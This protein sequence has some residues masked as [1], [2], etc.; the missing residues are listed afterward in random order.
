MKKYIEPEINISKF[1]CENIVTDS[2]VTDGLSQFVDD[3]IEVNTVKYQDIFET[4]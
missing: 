1:K 3:N 4:N 2:A